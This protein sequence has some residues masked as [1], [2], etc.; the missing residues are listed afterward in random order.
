MGKAEKEVTRVSSRR[1]LNWLGKLRWVNVVER[2]F[3]PKY[4]GT[5]KWHKEVYVAVEKCV[6]NHSVMS[7]DEK[8]IVKF[9]DGEVQEHRMSFLNNR[10]CSDREPRNDRVFRSTGRPRRVEPP[11]FCGWSVA[12]D[13]E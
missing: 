9:N 6:V 3:E 2:I 10:G 4:H 13:S 12:Y 11:L 7:A 5:G 8:S 1:N